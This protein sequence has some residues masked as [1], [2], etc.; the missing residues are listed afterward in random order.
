MAS[1]G[2]SKL[3]MKVD[4]VLDFFQVCASEE[5]PLDSYPVLFNVQMILF[6]AAKAGA[7]QGWTSQLSIS[8]ALPTALGQT[9]TRREHVVL[10]GAG[11]FNP[12]EGDGT[13][14]CF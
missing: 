13:C 9:F 1:S 7:C 6:Q 4:Y 2:I 8:C 10:H 14:I 11:E 3:I 5:D 12:K